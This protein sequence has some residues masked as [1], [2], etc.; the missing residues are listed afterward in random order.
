MILLN[1]NFAP[2]LEDHL[3]FYNYDMYNN[4]HPQML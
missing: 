1:S 3:L 4:Q 2:S